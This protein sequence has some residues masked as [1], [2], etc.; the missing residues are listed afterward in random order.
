MTV[1]AKIRIMITVTI[2]MAFGFVLMFLKE[3][4]IPC[5][6]LAGVWVMHILIFIFGIKTYV[7]DVNE[8]EAVKQKE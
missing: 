3:I 8:K 5:Y 6:I 2:V 1:G 7:P 4:Y